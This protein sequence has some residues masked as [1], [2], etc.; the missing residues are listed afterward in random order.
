MQRRVEEPDRHREPG[1]RLE[2]ALEVLLLERQEPGQRL[3]PLVLSRGHD[4][5][6]DERQPVFDHEHVLGAA[7]PDPLGAELA[8]LGG[9]RRRVG[10]RAH[11]QPADVVGPAEQELEV[12]VDLR[13]DEVDRAEDDL[14]R[15]AVDRDHVSLCEVVGAQPRLPLFVVDREPV[16]GRHARL[17]HPA[18]DDRGVRGEAAYRGQNPLRLDHAVEVVGARLLPHEDD[19]LSGPASLLGRVRI[20]DDRPRRGS[21]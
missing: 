17:P 1:H 5:L 19:G 21:R 14:P 11:L 4:H 3:A 15:S 18:R 2:D 7:E 20:E 13:R 6:P 16:A 8:R 12:L 9:V 10:V